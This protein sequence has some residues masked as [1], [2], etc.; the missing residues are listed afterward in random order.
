MIVTVTF[1]IADRVGVSIGL[2][3]VCLLI[4]WW[5]S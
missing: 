3:D 5:M 1:R 4:V 2:G